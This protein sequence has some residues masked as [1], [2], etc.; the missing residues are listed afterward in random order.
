MCLH[1]SVCLPANRPKFR[2]VQRKRG[3]FDYLRQVQNG[4]INTRD[5]AR[6]Q[7]MQ[8]GLTQVVVISYCLFHAQGI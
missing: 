8:P 4:K 1:M 7:V 3:L 6:K 5:K 2:K